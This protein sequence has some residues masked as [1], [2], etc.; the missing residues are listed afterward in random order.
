MIKT[1]TFYI[2]DREFIKTYSDSGKYVTR[3]GEIFEEACDPVE[4]GREY[5]EG[6]LMPV[7]DNSE[8]DSAYA[9]A[10]RILMGALD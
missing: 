2:N 6:D 1:E 3:D 10:G 4:F 7:I 5:A 8:L 9:T